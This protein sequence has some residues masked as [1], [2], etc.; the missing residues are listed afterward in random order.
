RQRSERRK[1]QKRSSNVPKTDHLVPPDELS[2]IYGS[3]DAN[4]LQKV[5]GARQPH[6]HLPP[7][8]R[9]LPSP[10]CALRATVASRL[11]QAT[12]LS[13]R[14]ASRRRREQC[15][16]AFPTMLTGP[17]GQARQRP[18]TL[19]P[20]SA[21]PSWCTGVCLPRKLGRVRGT[22]AVG[23]SLRYER[24]RVRALNGP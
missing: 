24:L 21:R 11:R 9:P 6:S 4:G 12:E 22:V 19:V 23:S 18:R 14:V 3:R 7:D 2:Q 8:R 1:H 20:V 16:R 13:P 15:G 10:S 17:G 5:L